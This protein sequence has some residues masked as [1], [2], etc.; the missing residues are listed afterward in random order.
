ML[1]KYEY[2]TRVMG[3]R[4]TMR[5]RCLAGGKSTGK[6]PRNLI[7]T[8]KRTNTKIRFGVQSIGVKNHVI[9]MLLCSI[10]KQLAGQHILRRYRSDY[11]ISRKSLVGYLVL[12]AR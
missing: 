8:V 10:C 12:L 5:G 2:G 11:C 6:A 4:W 9:L 1:Y 7:I 3:A